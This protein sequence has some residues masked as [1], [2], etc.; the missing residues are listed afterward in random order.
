MSWTEKDLSIGFYNKSRL[1]LNEREAGESTMVRMET[2]QV[3]VS[4]CREGFLD[5]HLSTTGVPYIRRATKHNVVATA[6]V[7]MTM[8]SVNFNAHQI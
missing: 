4:W 8:S 2:V 5:P 1:R 6:S 3:E 7:T